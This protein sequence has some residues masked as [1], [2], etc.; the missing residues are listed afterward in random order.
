MHKIKDVLK[1]K[2][3]DAQLRAVFCNFSAIGTYIFSN[4]FIY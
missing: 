1:E 3:K 4:L 2:R